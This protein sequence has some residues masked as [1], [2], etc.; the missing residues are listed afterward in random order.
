MI[1]ERIWDK[2]ALAWFLRRK[3]L[4]L[5][6]LDW[7]SF[8]GIKTIHGLKCEVIH[9]F[10]NQFVLQLCVLGIKSQFVL[11]LCQW[12]R[13]RWWI[14]VC[15]A[16]RKSQQFEH[17][18]ESKSPWLAKSKRTCYK[19]GW[20]FSPDAGGV[21]F[22]PVSETSHNPWSLCWAFRVDRRNFAKIL[23][24]GLR[25]HAFAIQDLWLWAQICK[26]QQKQRYSFGNVTEV[27]GSFQLVESGRCVNL[28][29]N[30]LKLEIHCVVSHLWQYFRIVLKCFQ[31]W[32]GYKSWNFN[33]VQPWLM[34]HFVFYWIEGLVSIIHIM[35]A[36]GK[37]S[38]IL[39]PPFALSTL[40]KNHLQIFENSGG[41]F[42]IRSS[43]DNRPPWNF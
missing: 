37:H 5:Q 32:G 3:K 35:A 30:T 25:S 41:H 22:V 13:K 29:W 10:K 9:S 19:I 24:W 36:L 38:P 17:C 33:F 40:E 23:W 11:Q 12:K 7:R 6:V 14:Q 31:N 42:Q 21:Q 39:L 34:I 43:N 27:N 1:W 16:P 26:Q 20:Q 8:L 2:I 28:L 18:S 4:S 15:G